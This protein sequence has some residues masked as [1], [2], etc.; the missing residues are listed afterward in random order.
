MNW[1]DIALNTASTLWVLYVA[2]MII[3]QGK[4]IEKLQKEVEA[5]K[6]EVM[7]YSIRK[8]TK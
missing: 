2:L 6:D 1:I 4:K 7:P 5:L 8:E 3:Y